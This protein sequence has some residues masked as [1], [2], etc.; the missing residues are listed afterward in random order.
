MIDREHVLHIA[1]LARLNLTEEEVGSFTRQLGSILEY[2]DQ[3]DRAPTEGIEATSVMACDH[4]SMRD[5]VVAASLDH[6]AILGNGPQVKLD[7]FAVP[8]VIGG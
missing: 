3:L 7:H 4:D 6:E 2:V 1:K 5:D 8:K